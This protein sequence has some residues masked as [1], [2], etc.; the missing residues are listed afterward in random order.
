[1]PHMKLFKTL[2]ATTFALTAATATFAATQQPADEAEKV[3]VST[4]E[5][6]GDAATDNSAAAQPQAGQPTTESSAEGSSSSPVTTQ[7]NQ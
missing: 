7:P 3:V 6:P 4:Q 1:M 2:L 5:Q